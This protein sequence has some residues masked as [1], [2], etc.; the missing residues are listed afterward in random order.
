VFKWNWRDYWILLVRIERKV[1]TSDTCQ[2]CT[3]IVHVHALICKNCVLL[4]LK[5]WNFS[6]NWMHWSLLGLLLRI[7]TSERPRNLH[8]LFL[9]VF[10]S[11]VLPSSRLVSVAKTALTN[12]NPRSPFALICVEESCDVV[13][14]FRHS[15]HSNEISRR[16][17]TC[18]E[19]WLQRFLL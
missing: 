19:F 4:M 6:R 16:C 13:L 9:M 5:F 7:D 17:L 3:L 18:S 2:A 11:P 1:S 15:E 10:I 14:Y 12:V 8:C